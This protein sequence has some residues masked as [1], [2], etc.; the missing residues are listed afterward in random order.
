MHISVSSLSQTGLA[1]GVGE[2]P[3]KQSQKLSLPGGQ[4]YSV[5]GVPWME[6]EGDASRMNDSA[7]LYWQKE[8]ANNPVK[9]K[10]W[11]EDWIVKEPMNVSAPQQ[12]SI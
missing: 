5:Q 3:I 10:A 11:I 2:Y 4:K 9:R 1:P 7:F 6:I 8:L 12:K